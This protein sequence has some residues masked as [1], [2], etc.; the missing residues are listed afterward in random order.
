MTTSK[1]QYEFACNW[2]GLSMSIHD[3]GIFCA[4]HKEGGHPTCG[5]RHFKE[6]HKDGTLSEG[7][8]T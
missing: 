8:P 1:T 6:E 3:T 4:K 2:C 7:E 5:A